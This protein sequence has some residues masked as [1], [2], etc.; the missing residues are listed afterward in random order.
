[1]LTRES[2]DD[3]G[4]VTIREVAEPAGVS[5][6][7]VSRVLEERRT[8]RSPNADRVRKAAVE[9]GYSESVRV[10]PA[11]RNRPARSGW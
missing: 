6:A 8:S 3:R 2:A 1:M 9:L 11:T 10:Q 5:I 7:T 4:P